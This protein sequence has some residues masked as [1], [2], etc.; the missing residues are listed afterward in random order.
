MV[1]LPFFKKD[2]LRWLSACPSSRSFPLSFSRFLLASISRIA[3]VQ[4]P[5]P[6]D[7]LSLSGLSARMVDWAH[8][9]PF[10]PTFFPFGK[11]LSTIS[12]N[13]FSAPSPSGQRRSRDAS[14]ECRSAPIALCPGLIFPFFHEPSPVSHPPRKTA[15]RL[16]RFCPCEP[17]STT[18]VSRSCSPIADQDHHSGFEQSLFF[19]FVFFFFVILTTVTANIAQF[20][21]LCIVRAKLFPLRLPPGTLS[22]RDSRGPLC[23]LFF[24]IVSPYPPPPSERAND[25]SCP[26]GR[27]PLPQQRPSRPTTISVTFPSGETPLPP[28]RRSKYRSWC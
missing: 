28:L 10:R 26:K 25:C 6:R 2:G 21:S 4:P 16:R 23:D 20:F 11:V 19:F 12:D 27:I 5:L 13:R 7:P 22:H 9:H 18:M 15:V 14:R 3:F 24:F 17:L 1:R 8:T